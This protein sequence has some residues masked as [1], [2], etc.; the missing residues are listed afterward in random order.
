[1]TDK[2]LLDNVG[3]YTNIEVRGSINEGF[4]PNL[5]KRVECQKVLVDLDQLKLINSSGV[6][7]WINFLDLLSEKDIVYRKCPKI[8]IDQLNMVNGMLRDNI[9]IESFYVPFYSEES[10]E[11]KDVLM[12][13][14][15]IQ[16]INNLPEQKD[17]QG[18][19]L[20][21]DDIPQK[22]FKFLNR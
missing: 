11:E 2:I 12:N 20:E 18:N 4:D 3:D 13:P 10:D 17:S 9:S 1:M 19:L 22:Y 16:D 5:A 15:D 7:E 6:R 21:F 8:F 14:S